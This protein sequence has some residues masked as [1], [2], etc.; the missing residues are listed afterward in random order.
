[1]D[2]A[3]LFS[4]DE[5]FLSELNWNS[6]DP[7]EIEGL[8]GEK[9]LIFTYPLDETDSDLVEEGCFVALPDP[10]YS[11]E[12]LLYEVANIKKDDLIMHVECNHDYYNMVSDDLVTW[13]TNEESAAT[14]LSHSLATT[15]YV[16][17]LSENERLLKR[18][19]YQKNPLESIRYVEREWGGEL[20]FA[21]TIGEDYSIERYVD[22]LD[23]IGSFEGTRFE[24][25]HNLAEFEHTVDFT[26][27]RTALYGFGQGQQVEGETGDTEKL[28][29]A[30]VVWSKANGDPTDKPLGQTW[31][32]DSEAL[33]MYGKSDGSG[34]KLH[35]FGVY[36][37]QAETELGLLWETWAQLEQTNTPLVN[38]SAKLVDLGAFNPNFAHE[39]ARLGDDVFVIADIGKP[40][41]AQARII[42]FTR[43]RK[44]PENNEVEIGN[45][46][47][48]G[49]SLA[50]D[51]AQFKKEVEAR[52]PI[53]DSG[54]TA[55]I[56]I[57][58]SKIADTPPPV[59]VNVEATG[60]FRSVI[61][62]WDYNPSILIAEYQ[63]YA[64]QIQGFT[65]QSTDLVFNGKASSMVHEVATNQTWYYRVR[66]VNPHGTVSAFSPEVSASTIQIVFNDISDAAIGADKLQD[67]IIDSDKIVNGAINNTK[68]ADL[69]V[70]AAKLANGSVG[71]TQ[72]AIDAVTNDK[73]ADLAVQA[74]QLASGAV[75][76]TKLFDSAVTNTKLAANAVTEAKLAASAVT[77][78]KL[79]DL[80]ID[81]AKLASGAVTETKVGTGA[82]TNTKLA[83]LAVDAA[84][85]ASG[86]VGTTQL[87]IDAVTSEKLADLSVLAANLANGAVIDTKIGLGAVTNTKLGD[88]AI[89]AAKLADGAVT[90]AKVGDGAISNIKLANLAVDAAKLAD[91]A[92]STLKIATDAITNDKLADLAVQAAQLASG[93]VTEVKLGDN[94]VTNAKIA[95]L[96]VGTAEIANTAITSAKIA[97]LAVGTA[98]IQDLAVSGAKIANLAVGT[99]Q[100]ADTAI[101]SAKI[102]NLAVG[103]AAIANAAITDAKLDRASVNK[104][105]IGTADIAD[106]AIV[107]AK[108]GSLAV[109]SAAIQDLAVTNAKIAD[110]AV[111]TA[112]IADAAISTAKI[113]NLAV[114]NAAIANLAV[115]NGKIANLAV[116]STQI[117]DAAITTAKI[118]NLAVGSAAIADLAVG[119]GK[120]ADAAITNAKIANLAVGTAA[121][122]DAAITNAKI[123]SINAEKITAGTLLVHSQQLAKGTNFGDGL[124]LIGISSG[125]TAITETDAR[126]AYLSLSKTTTGEA[127]AY[128]KR[129]ELEGGRQVT[130]SLEYKMDEGTTIDLFVLA[131]ATPLIEGNR[132]D[133]SFEFAYGLNAAYNP[134]PT[135]DGWVRVYRVVNIDPTVKSG[136]LRFDHNGS[137]GVTSKKVRFRNV[138]VNYG[139]IA[140]AWQPHTEESIQAGGIIAEKIAAGAIT[141]EKMQA[142]SITAVSG[143]IADAAITTAKIAN[144]AVGTAAIA[145]LGVTN[146]KIAN[147]AVKTA[148]IEDAA[149]TTAKIANL[150]VGTAAIQDAAITNAKILALDAAK[151][152]TGILD[153][154]RVKIGSGTTFDE[155]FDPTKIEIGGTNLLEN[156]SFNNSL[157]NWGNVGG[158]ALDFNTRH[159]T[160]AAVYKDN[161]AGTAAAE[162]S[163][164]TEGILPNA[165][166]TISFYAKGTGTLNVYGIERLAA[167]NSTTAVYSENLHTYQLTSGFQRFTFT[168]TTQPDIQ[169]LDLLFR[170]P[171]GSKAHIVMPQLETG[172]K[173]T[174]YSVAEIDWRSDINNA[175]LYANAYTEEYSGEAVTL[176]GEWKYPNTTFIDG[177]DLYNNSITTNKIAVG[178]I[179]AN[180]AIIAD[181]AII[182]AKIADLAVSNAKIANL[183]V[184]EGK[185][186]N[187]AVTNAKIADLAVTNAKI[188]YAAVGT[189]EIQDAAIT[190]AKIS[191]IT[192]EKITSGTLSSV[193]IDV[194]TDIKVGQNMYMQ[195]EYANRFNKK[196]VSFYDPV[197]TG[198]PSYDTHVGGT[199]L[200][201][202]LTGQD[203]NVNA[204]TNS[205]R[206]D[207]WAWGIG[208][209]APNINFSGQPTTSA[210]ESGYAGVGG[211]SQNTTTSAI[212][213]VGVQFPTAKSYTPS[214]VTLY[215]SAYNR[216]GYAI[217]ITS[218]GFWLYV[219]GNGTTGQYGYWRGHYTA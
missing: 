153:A 157:S 95:D 15:R 185:I 40:F 207:I 88:L 29:F 203:V 145:N 11:G 165:Q 104:I 149:I 166:Y 8:D 99:A 75:T 183:T 195:Y 3:L 4:I 38:M 113:A 66:S 73:I 175:E 151:I 187:L 101:T 43:R 127:Y 210:S 192:A 18:A 20:R 90:V 214:S 89:T 17:R 139:T 197:L 76:D 106:A 5:E 168:F 142:N 191:N 136:V 115:T 71:T 117:A 132:G 27:V 65:P 48:R 154:A 54:G 128:G 52:T 156:S 177:G 125:I 116:G 118:A 53:W 178:A 34:G 67:F 202:D 105:V 102:A 84:K 87:A 22:F 103:N 201:L 57:D 6:F 96:A 109:G 51:F 39:K 108:I 41:E 144:L 172:N 147:L 32:G 205:G 138:M 190:N 21:V 55:E 179:T 28:T 60:I 173:A 130:I 133:V 184:T 45:F 82:I 31:V 56:I 79:A 85:L 91:G 63:V 37:S 64:S 110:L 198:N 61:V 23:R 120:I 126:G 129:F 49:S 112:E 9:K 170:L 80:A 19:V 171:I 10:D 143:I 12:W 188:A 208:L 42:S 107:S 119:T 114:G 217:D 155:G 162:L 123:N 181:A 135:Q 148:N 69:A 83:D 161:T 193:T 33:A 62:E 160:K 124:D 13:S 209:Y 25:G 216:T 72:L 182:T 152:T 167:Y 44:E 189:A 164:I 180:S 58:D 97:N 218:R 2:R 30:N 93:A 206:T 137:D 200:K 158:W 35:R 36:D 176:V 150:A 121:I 146:A 77:N 78:A 70:T 7:E 47:P 199:Y 59:P 92:V 219:N 204:N 100:I 174:A 26:N 81:A 74:A 46:L 111:N 50:N 131:S 215:G 141:T 122:Q 68:L 194:G 211:T 1:M 213:G 212:A 134:T 140:A 186:A 159:M 14:A 16:P 196:K 98:A 86:A 24:F 94:A 163:K 169:R